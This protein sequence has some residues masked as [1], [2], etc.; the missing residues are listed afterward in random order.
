MVKEV[1]RT[2]CLD[3]SKPLAHEFR[4]QFFDEQ[5]TVPDCGPSLYQMVT[6]MT[7]GSMP[8]SNP[9]YAYPDLGDDDEAHDHPDYE[10]LNHM[11]MVHKEEYADEFVNNP[12]NYEK[13]VEDVSAEVS[14]SSEEVSAKPSEE[15]PK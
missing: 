8:G 11:D 3:P 2:V 6:S 13:E 14:T 1:V 4:H 12:K 7:V 15:K 5:V 9:A 10:K